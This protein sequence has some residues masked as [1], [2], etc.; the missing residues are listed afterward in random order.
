LRNPLL[1]LLV[2]ALAVPTATSAQTGAVAE[3]GGFAAPK[4]PLRAQ[5]LSVAHTAVATT[6]GALLL[7]HGADSDLLAIPGFGLLAYGVLGAPSAGSVYAHDRTRTNVGLTVR[8]A[9]GALVL[10]SAWRH[11]L[12]GGLNPDRPDGDLGWD[13]LNATGAAVV[14][15]GTVY[16]IATAP[17][18]AR[19]FNR[20]TGGTPTIDLSVVPTVVAGGGGVR[21]SV[22]VRF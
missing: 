22:D 9:G 5:L 15:A 12:S 8:S 7:R 13:A 1:I 19:E 2:A 21:T 14:V 16:S 10:A 20:R 11:I 18:S 4:S 3:P 6:G 17:R